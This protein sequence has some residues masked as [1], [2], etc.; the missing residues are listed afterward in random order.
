MM[1]IPYVMV[2]AALDGVYML[3]NVVI[4]VQ[5]KLRLISSVLATTARTLQLSCIR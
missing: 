1:Q 4:C 3:A 5:V 2:A